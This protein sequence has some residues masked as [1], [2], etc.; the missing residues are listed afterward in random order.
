MPTYTDHFRKATR[1]REVFRSEGMATL[2]TD[3][4]ESQT[5]APLANLLPAFGP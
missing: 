1:C 4:C 5:F 2:W 3:L